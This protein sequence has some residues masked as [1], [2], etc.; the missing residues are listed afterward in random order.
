MGRNKMEKEF[1]NKLNQREINPSAQ[2]WDRLDAMLTV[3]EEKKP[4]RDFG[5]LYMAASILGFLFVGTIYLSQTEEIVDIKRNEVVLPDGQNEKGTES[6][7]KAAEEVFLITKDQESIVAAAEP[8]VNRNANT[9][10]SPKNKN[11]QNPST[12]IRQTENKELIATTQTRNNQSGESNLNPIIN[13][14]TEQV[15]PAKVDELLANAPVQKSATAKTFVKVNAKNL[16]SQVDGELNLSFREKM[17]RNIG[18]SYQEVADAVSTRN[19]Q[20]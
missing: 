1:S 19:I 12:A 10:S 3:A 16:L 5:W 2:A 4:K 11:N 17:L 13:Q 6:S 18:K 8:R 9:H 20:E 7:A 15:S 14:K